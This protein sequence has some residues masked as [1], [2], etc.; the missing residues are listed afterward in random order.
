MDL[1]IA[2]L[3]KTAI[4]LIAFVAVMI[5]GLGSPAGVTWHSTSSHEFGPVGSGLGQSQPP[6]CYR[7]R[8]QDH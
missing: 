5:M 2:C 8:H 3:R 6:Y 7:D 1:L 4:G